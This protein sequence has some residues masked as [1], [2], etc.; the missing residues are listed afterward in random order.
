[1][2]FVWSIL[3]RLAIGRGWKA[4]IG[5]LRFNS[6][7]NLFALSLQLPIVG[8]VFIVRLENGKISLI[9]LLLRSTL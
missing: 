8:R 3:V 4:K 5:C 1:M 7:Q 2:G 6:K 9:Q